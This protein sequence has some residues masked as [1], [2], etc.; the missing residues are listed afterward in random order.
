[1][2]LHLNSVPLLT[3]FQRLTGFQPL[4][5]QTKLCPYLHMKQRRHFGFSD[6]PD[7]ISGH[8]LSQGTSSTWLISELL[9]YD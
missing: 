1:M 6:L 9:Y 7:M 3:C 2:K 5:F 8:N 4:R